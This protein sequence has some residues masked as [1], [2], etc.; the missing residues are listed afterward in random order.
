MAIGKD[1][2]GGGGCDILQ[3]GHWGSQVNQYT[4][5][6]NASFGS[7]TAITGG[8]RFTGSV[9]LGAG[10]WVL[11]YEASGCFIPT[12]GI[13]S[14]VFPWSESQ[15]KFSCSTSAPYEYCS[16]SSMNQT[17]FTV[18]SDTSCTLSQFS[19]GGDSS[20]ID[21]N[22]YYVPPPFSTSSTAIATSSSL[23][24]SYSASTTPAALA[25]QCSLSGNIFSEA[26]CVAFSYLFVPNPSTINGLVS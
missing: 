2:S 11:L 3:I 14:A 6:S 18:C 22:L 17:M 8:T 25:G 12:R 4:F 24:G 15:G 10:T 16:Q 26:L 1:Y 7:P 5:N 13:S 20:S 21:W 9:T 19:Q 23:W